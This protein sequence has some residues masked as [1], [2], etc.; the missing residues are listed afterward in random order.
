M[1][2]IPIKPDLI[3]NYL[4]EFAR[5]NSFLENYQMAKSSEANP[6]LVTQTHGF[7]MAYELRNTDQGLVCDRNRSEIMQWKVHAQT[8]IIQPKEGKG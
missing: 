1:S 3:F 8:V 7:N 2:G 6:E 4:A 5:L